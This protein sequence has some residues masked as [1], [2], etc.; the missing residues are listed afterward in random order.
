MPAILG[1][2]LF[3]I[4][5]LMTLAVTLGAPLGEFTLGGKHKILPPR[6]RI[7]SGISFFIQLLAIFVILQVGGF[8]TL[9]LPLPAARGICM[10]FAAYLAV[11][12]I[13]NL[14]SDS[15]KEKYVM[16]PLSVIAAICFG[17]TALIK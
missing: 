8:I 12:T 15:K 16:T 11:N 17:M 14:L 5:A 9:P 10:F 2:I 3:G 4:I 1:A 6:M 7:A 13:M